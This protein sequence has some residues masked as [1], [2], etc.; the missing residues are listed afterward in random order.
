[1]Q[2]RHNDSQ[3]N[4]RT[5]KLRKYSWIVII[6]LLQMQNNCQVHI[7]LKLFLAWDWLCA[8]SSNRHDLRDATLLPVWYG[9]MR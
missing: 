7:A 1:M 2:A 5:I 3:G 4:L 6:E 8:Y 9:I